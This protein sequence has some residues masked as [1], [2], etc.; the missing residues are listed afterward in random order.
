MAFHDGF[1]WGAATSSY[2]VEGGAES[3]GRKPSIWDITSQKKKTARYGETG[4]ISTDHYHKFR[5]DVE[6]FKKIG[7]KAYRFS[8][9]WSRVIPDGIGKVNE[10]GLKFYS[11]LVDELLNAGIEPL[12][13]LFH[14]DLPYALYLKGGY[15]NPEFPQWFQQYT[16]VI[17]DALSDRVK[18]WIT[19]NE[20]QCV[21]GCGYWMGEH[22]P[23]LKCDNHTIIVMI[24]NYLKAHGIAVK[25]IRKYAKIN[26][27]IGIAPMAPVTVPED[28]SIRNISIARE[29][30]FSMDGIFFSK[31]LY[32]DPMILGKYPD[33]CWQVFGDEM[34]NPSKED[35]DLI[36]Q[37]LDFYGLN[38]Y[39]SDENNE[40]G[41]YP[42][43]FYQGGPHT[44]TNWVINEK[45]IYWSAKFMY[46][47]YKLPVLITENGMANADIISIDGYV[48][49]PQRIDFIHRY[50]NMLK[51]VIEEGVPVIGYIY[52]SALDN[53]EWADG[54]DKRFGLI[55]VDYRTQKRIIKDSAFWLKEVIE[56]N[57]TN[58]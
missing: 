7:L 56:S 20:P 2:Q 32:S 18:Y 28:D 37:P 39:F 8:I 49:D 6:L 26:S 46:E 24:H 47:R 29:K 11:D 41:G 15:G 3:D 48:H 55:Y 16:K 25:T 19:M 13:T 44:D 43:G 50:L 30:T 1:L 36:C 40:N 31:S 10:K 53:Y 21:F 58:L 45:S 57:G 33:E 23:F 52:W 34:I 9:S 27:K 42:D 4:N 51:N 17:V 12:V 14:W 22:A 54:Y 5:E 35:M 38:I